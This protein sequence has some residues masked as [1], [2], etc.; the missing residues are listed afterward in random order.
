MTW[1]LVL[2]MVGLL[3]L[4][5]IQLWRVRQRLENIEAALIF[6]DKAARKDGHYTIERAVEQLRLIETNTSG[7]SHAINT[8]EKTIIGIDRKARTGF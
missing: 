7:I 6:G 5:W 8:L 4:I 2:I 1:L 3:I